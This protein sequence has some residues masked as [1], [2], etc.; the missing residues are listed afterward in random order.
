M[1]SSRAKDMT[2]KRFDNLVVIE[3]AENKIYP[4]GRVSACWLCKCDCGNKVI[5]TGDALRRGLTRSCGCLRDK[6]YNTKHRKVNDYNLDGEYGVGYTSNGEEFYFDLEDYNKIKDYSWHLQGDGYIGT[7]ISGGKQLR[8]H[9]LLIPNEQKID[10][11]N[12]CL[13]DNRKSN[14]R[15]V[16]TSQNGMNRTTSKNNKSGITG[17]CYNKQY[18]KY[19]ATIKCNW[20]N[21]FIGG[22]KDF[23]KASLARLEAEEKYYGDFMPLDRKKILDYIRNGGELE[24]GNKELINNIINDIL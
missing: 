11:I 19:I 23:T 7:H 10:H 1:G 4:T 15:I 14:L 17:V 5:V 12:H 22:Y 8:M 6:Y 24:Y 20:K 21:I 2:G 18:D 3:R 9:R 13:V 16:T